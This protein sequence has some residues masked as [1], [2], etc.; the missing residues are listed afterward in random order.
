MLILRIAL[1]HG[2][3]KFDKSRLKQPN[4]ITYDNGHIVNV[5]IV[6]EVGPSTFSNSSPTLKIVFLVQLL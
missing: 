5:F 2:L 1:L 3:I 6:Y 4:K